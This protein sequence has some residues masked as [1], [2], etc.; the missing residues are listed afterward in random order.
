MFKS[1]KTRIATAALAL[2]PSLVFASEAA[3][4]Q[5]PAQQA[6]H[7]QQKYKLPAGLR[8][9]T[10]LRPDQAQRVSHKKPKMERLKASAES[11][12]IQTDRNERRIVS[13]RWQPGT[14]AGR[15]DP[16]Q[17]VIEGANHGTQITVTKKGPLQAIQMP[18]VER[19]ALRDGKGRAVESAKFRKIV[20]RDYNKQLA[21]AIA[22]AR[23]DEALNSA[24]QN[25][26]SSAQP[27]VIDSPAALPT[28]ST[29]TVSAKDPFGRKYQSK[30][31]IVDGRAYTDTGFSPERHI[32]NNV[33][34]SERVQ[35]GGRLQPSE[36]AQLVRQNL[37]STPVLERIVDKG[38]QKV[39]G[40][41]QRV[42]EKQTFVKL[43]GLAAFSPNATVTVT[44]KRME[45][46]GGESA[47]KARVT[48]KS[49]RYG[50]GD[51]EVPAELG[52]E[53][54]IHVQTR[55]G[56]EIQG[57][58]TQTEIKIPSANKDSKFMH[59]RYLSID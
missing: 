45:A 21:K 54:R 11:W 57:A 5:G 38:Y 53:L 22:T 51:I 18:D 25:A 13:N 16:Y 26:P 43:L 20:N 9:V 58:S 34:V 55:T 14:W 8:V 10:G 42:K 48:F 12:A 46:L 56:A 7:P 4:Q 35:T 36:A 44:N 50:A 33:H 15:T 37:R 49:N 27:V 19:L 6:Q 31:I 59:D 47:L 30:E 41:W 2:T 24:T 3:Q 39:G 23:A 29:L 17:I 1:W 28:N 52:D 32:G 40:K